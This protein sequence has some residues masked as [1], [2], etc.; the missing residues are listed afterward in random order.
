MR[1]GRPAR[2]VPGTA[3]ACGLLLA[4]MLAGCGGPGT[5]SAADQAVSPAGLSASPGTSPQPTS[6]SQLARRRR[7]TV[8]RLGPAFAPASLDVVTGQQFLVVIRRGFNV[9]GLILPGACRAG[10][11]REGTGVLLSVRCTAA[12]YLYTARRPGIAYLAAAVRPRCA[13]LTACPKWISVP[14]LRVSISR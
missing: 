4:V 13:P 6:P 14:R 1:T 2:L 5:G 9:S 11:A 7:I 10:Q 8:V 12:G 3:A